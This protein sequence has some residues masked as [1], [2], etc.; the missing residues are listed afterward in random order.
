MHQQK[1]QRQQKHHGTTAARHGRSPDFLVDRSDDDD[2]VMMAE[3]LS[4][5]ISPLLGPPHNNRYRHGMITSGLSLMEFNNANTITT[6]TASI[7]KNGFHNGGVDQ[8]YDEYNTDNYCYG[9]VATIHDNRLQTQV[10]GA[11]S[12]SIE[13]PTSPTLS[14]CYQSGTT[15]HHPQY[16]VDGV[17]KFID[18]RKQSKHQDDDTAIQQLHTPKQPLQPPQANNPA[19]IS[20]LFGLVNTAI[21]LPIIMSFGSIIYQHE[22][23]RPHLSILMKLT[24]ISGAVHQLVFSTMSS[25]PFA[26]GQVQDS[27]GFGF[28]PVGFYSVC[29]SHHTVIVSLSLSVSFQQCIQD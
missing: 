13:H 14:Q 8:L 2:D 20:I 10:E 5:S 9:A 27:G 18:G 4:T 1:L 15:H 19:Y 6:A 12:S 25:L 29:V 7:T 24:V 16:E 26:V 28:P 21:V 3:T 11:G 22:F 17:N 23:F